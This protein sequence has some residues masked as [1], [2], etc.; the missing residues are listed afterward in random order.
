MCEWQVEKKWCGD[1][2]VQFQTIGTIFVY[3]VAEYQWPLLLTWFNFN[4]SMNNWLHPF[5]SV[6]WNNLSIPKLQLCNHWSL[7]MDKYFHHILYWVS[8]Y[9]S[10]QGLKLIHISKGGYWSSAGTVITISNIG[11]HS[12]LVIRCLFYLHGLT[13]ILVWRSNWDYLSMLWFKLTS[14]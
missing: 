9:L 4:P 5:Q 8:D 14:C 7:G 6:G 10:M 13:F 2:Y 3:S 1:D 11:R 12:L